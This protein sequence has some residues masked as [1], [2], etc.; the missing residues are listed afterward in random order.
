MVDRSTA[1]M[2]KGFYAGGRNKQ[3]LLLRR[4]YIGTVSADELRKLETLVAAD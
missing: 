4:I 2:E 1:L 3:I